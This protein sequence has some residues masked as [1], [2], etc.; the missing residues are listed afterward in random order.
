MRSMEQAGIKKNQQ[1]RNVKEKHTHRQHKAETSEQMLEHRKV[2][3]N[4]YK[5][6]E[7]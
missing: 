7:L 2:M 6:D 4:H 3:W 1:Q 5:P